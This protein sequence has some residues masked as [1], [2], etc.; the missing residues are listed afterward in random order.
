MSGLVVGSIDDHRTAVVVYSQ[1]P[2]AA[3][4]VNTFDNSSTLTIPAL[5][6]LPAGGSITG[7]VQ[8]LGGTID[9]TNFEIDRDRDKLTGAA[10]QG[11]MIT[12]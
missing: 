12:N 8:G 10:G 11:F 1:D 5:T 2:G 3:D 7:S 6:A 4:A 9:P